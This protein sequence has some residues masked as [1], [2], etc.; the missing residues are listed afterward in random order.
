MTTI[1]TDMIT[2]VVT[3][4]NL[5]DAHG[6]GPEVLG[7]DK[8]TAM[9]QTQREAIA[10]ACHMAQPAAYQNEVAF[11]VRN[12]AGDVLH[13]FTPLSDPA[14]VKFIEGSGCQECDGVGCTECDWHDHLAQG[15][16]D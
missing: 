13:S 14:F 11:A 6:T 1:T 12:E 7:A 15:A 9:N 8:L 3:Y 16:T 2:L 5:T 4:H 10:S